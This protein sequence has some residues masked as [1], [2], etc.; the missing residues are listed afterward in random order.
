MD[1]ENVAY[2]NN[3]ILFGHK[4]RNSVIYNN[5]DGTGGDYFKL[6]KP[7]TEQQIP[8]VLIHKSKWVEVTR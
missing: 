6:N 3:G 1:K 2:L 5:M 4:K 8:Y 7:E